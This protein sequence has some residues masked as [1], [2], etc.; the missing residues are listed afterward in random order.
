MKSW[1]LALPALLALAASGCTVGQH[2]TEV[3]ALQNENRNLEDNLYQQQAALKDLCQQLDA[4]RK[5]NEALH[6]RLQDLSPGGLEM[7]PAQPAASGSGAGSSL[8]V[9]PGR[10]MP[11]SQLPGWLRPTAPP[12][13]P[14]TDRLPKPPE[15]ESPPAIQAP[16]FTPPG[17]VPPATEAPPFAPPSAA[18]PAIEAPPTDAPPVLKPLPGAS[19]SPAGHALRAVSPAP[20]LGR[21]VEGD[22][23]KVAAITIRPVVAGGDRAG[24]PPGGDGIALWIEPRDQAG[25]MVRAS[26]PVSVVVLDPDPSVAGESARVARW[27]F[28]SEATA[29]F[30]RK[31]AT[32]EGIFVELTWPGDPPKHRSLEVFVRYTTD[33]GRKIEARRPIHLDLANHAEVEPHAVWS[34][35]VAPAPVTT[36]AYPSDKSPSA[37]AKEG[38]AVPDASPSQRPRSVAP[39]GDESAEKPKLQP[40][41]WSPDRP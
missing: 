41:A 29:A 5:D 17:A 21:A 37:T 39:A 36:T 15:E 38:S 10:P 12:N 26:A 14:S 33:D 6:H 18:P 24:Q 20:P 25:S 23:T 22:N 19:V 32:A 27:D 1:R 35:R 9:E 11:S 2:H 28:A 16:P 4:C 31:T 30:Y 3:A 34:R 8:S 40:P 7:T 13:R